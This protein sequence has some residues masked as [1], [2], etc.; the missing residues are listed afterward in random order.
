[1]ANLRTLLQVFFC[2]EK[3][4]DGWQTNTRMS[5]NKAGV[6][7]CFGREPKQR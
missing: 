6:S 4:D 2:A 1:L 5:N 7:F 3:G